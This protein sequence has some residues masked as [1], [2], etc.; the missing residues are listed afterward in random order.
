M[1]KCGKNPLKP[2][3]IRQ[4]SRKLLLLY[5]SFSPNQKYYKK[6]LT[7]CTNVVQY[8]KIST[9]YGRGE[10]MRLVIQVFRH[11]WIQFSMIT[12]ITMIYFLLVRMFI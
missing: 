8:L 7:F 9:I 2:H 3:E 1:L 12:L 11:L 6:Y 4:D 5:L 10:T